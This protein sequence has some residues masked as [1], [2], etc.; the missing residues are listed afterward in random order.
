MF[1]PLSF[2]GPPAVIE[3]NR[4]RLC[5]LQESH[6]GDLIALGLE[7]RIWAHYPI[8]L[9]VPERHLRHLM[10]IQEQ[11]QSG[12]SHA[13]VI[14]H[15]TT[16]VLL[17]MTRL[18]HIQTRHLQCETG[19]W[20]APAHW[21]SRINTESKFLLLNYCF[22]TLQLLRVQFRTDVRNIRSRC[23]LEKLGAHFEGVVRKERILE[24]GTVRD[25]ALYSIISS[26]WPDVKRNLLQ[27]IGFQSEYSLFDALKPESGTSVPAV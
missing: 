27:K 13:F 6:F 21:G 9:S 7:K 4:I 25:A 10:E 24:N 3:S 12:T 23:S 17:G 16:D 19:S 1:I 8:D 18:F 14:L 22:E 26:E 11:V 15:A 20:L 5:A 2:P